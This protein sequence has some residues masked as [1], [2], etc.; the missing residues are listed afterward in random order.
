ML[1][2]I[3]LLLSLFLTISYSY[4]MNSDYYNTLPICLQPALLA[5]P[6]EFYLN[7]ILRQEDW[8][9]QRYSF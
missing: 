4:N 9:M 3:S 2:L 8:G 6:R 1:F 7:E 5:Y